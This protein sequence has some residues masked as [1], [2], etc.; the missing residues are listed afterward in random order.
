MSLSCLINV[1]MYGCPGALR[2]MVL[3]SRRNDSQVEKSRITT[4]V[5]IVHKSTQDWQSLLGRKLNY[6]TARQQDDWLI[7]I[8]CKSSRIF[9]H[10]MLKNKSRGKRRRFCA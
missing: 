1:C 6:A 3:I 8:I 9:L 10:T 5:D 7:W 2:Q 4:E